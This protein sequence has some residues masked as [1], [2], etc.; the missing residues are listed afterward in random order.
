MAYR[1]VGILGVNI[2]YL[3]VTVK[4]MVPINFGDFFMKNQL[5]VLM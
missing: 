4:G 2:D 1:K 5:H 3:M